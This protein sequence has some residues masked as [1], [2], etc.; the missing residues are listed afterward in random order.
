MKEVPFENLNSVNLAFS[1][2]ASIY[3]TPT[4]R[5]LNHVRRTLNGFLLID[6]GA[7]LYEWDGHSAELTEGSLIYLP[8]HSHHTVSVLGDELSY[9]RVSFHATDMDDGETVV[10]SRTPLV[11]SHSAGGELT[12]IAKELTHI[13]FS[14][15][16]VLESTSLLCG[17]LAGCVRLM[18]S[19]RT[20]RIAAAVNY[21]DLHYTENTEVAALA[22]MCYLSEPHL[23]RLFR[24]ELGMS[25]VEYRSMIRVR[26]A[27][28]LLSD[29]ECSISEIASLLGFESVYYFSR[30][31]HR[32]E[33]MSAREYRS[34]LRLE[35][36]NDRPM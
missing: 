36:G 8:Y 31:F 9:Y 32:I 23:F 10:F 15:A 29:N 20:S 27:K 34:R 17:L 22:A 28:Q 18:N 33:G 25:P 26:K 21:L 4:W 14:K 7:C 6:R 16:D 2:I 11:V 35:K 13:T 3:Q 24:S 12:G 30:V 5:S 1:S 19:P